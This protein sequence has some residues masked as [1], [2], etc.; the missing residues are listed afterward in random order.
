MGGFG[1]GWWWRGE[2]WVYDG[3][4]GGGELWVFMVVDGWRV[5]LL[6]LNMRERERERERDTKINVKNKRIEK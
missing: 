5:W 2:I 4:G 1:C 6:L 3:G